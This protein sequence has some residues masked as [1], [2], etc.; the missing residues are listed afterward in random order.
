MKHITKEQLEKFIDAPVSQ[1][2]WDLMEDMSD[3]HCGSVSELAKK[4]RRY[5]RVFGRYKGREEKLPQTVETAEYILLR[6]KITPPR[7]KI[8][9]LLIAREAAKDEEV[10]KFRSKVLGHKL[11][12]PHEVEPWIQQQAEL[13]ASLSELPRDKNRHLWR[14]SPVLNLLS[15][16]PNDLMHVYTRPVFEPGILYQL[17]VLSER[18]AEEYHWSRAE[19]TFFVLADVSSGTPPPFVHTISARFILNIFSSWAMS[20]IELE[21]DPALTPR[22]VASEYARIRNGSIAKRPR[23]LSEKHLQLAEFAASEGIELIPKRPAGWELLQFDLV[24]TGKGWGEQMKKWNQ[25][26]AGPDSGYTLL[27]IFKRDCKQA[28]QHLLYPDYQSSENM[29]RQSLRRAVR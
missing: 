27:R 8:L 3:T 13:E 9:S 23:T 10:R 5:R 7:Q 11:L 24:S 16:I 21:I 20:R 28:L 14:N 12:K 19:A 26:Y 15:P 1:D 18:L 25:G 29:K 4:L 22:E 6:P 2:E 17:A